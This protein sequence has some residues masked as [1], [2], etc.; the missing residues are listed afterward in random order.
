MVVGYAFDSAIGDFFAAACTTSNACHLLSPI[1]CSHF[2]WPDECTGV[3]FSD[4]AIALLT[5]SFIVITMLLQ[6]AQIAIKKYWTLKGG[7]GMGRDPSVAKMPC[8]VHAHTE[9]LV[10]SDVHC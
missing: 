8:N 5:F 7:Q 2:V 4:C 6:T 9:K 10:E 1:L 3:C